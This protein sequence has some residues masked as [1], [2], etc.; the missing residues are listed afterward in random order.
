MAY[1][2][3]KSKAR[4]AARTVR[5]VEAAK[6]EPTP[7]EKANSRLAL[8]GG[9]EREVGDWLMKYNRNRVERTMAKFTEGWL[10]NPHYAMRW[11]D[12]VAEAVAEKRVLD[13]VDAILSAGKSVREVAVE[14]RY[15]ADRLA[16]HREH[17][18]SVM[19]NLMA[20]CDRAAAVK[21]AKE[22]ES[23]IVNFDAAVTCPLEM[24]SL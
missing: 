1:D 14:L 22:F 24:A 9:L 12:D 20:D 10:E 8:C 7:V 11:G 18:S 5:E 4:R 19:S 16:G 2:S 13:L 3:A 23:A 15:N 6:P 17:S 21:Y